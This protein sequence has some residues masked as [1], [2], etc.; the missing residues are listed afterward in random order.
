MQGPSS[1]FT[2]GA[3]LWL[4]LHNRQPQLQAQG[5]LLQAPGQL[6]QAQG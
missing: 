1:T 4:K 3:G 5:Q 6:L 2:H